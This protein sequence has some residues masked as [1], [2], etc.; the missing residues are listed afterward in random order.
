MRRSLVGS[1]RMLGLGFAGFYACLVLYNITVWLPSHFDE[2]P[3]PYF[4]LENVLV[5]FPDFDRGVWSH[6]DSF[7]PQIWEVLIGP[8]LVMSVGAFVSLKSRHGLRFLGLDFILLSSFS[9]MS[10]LVG[11]LAD[12]IGRWFDPSVIESPSRFL[13]RISLSA[14]VG[15]LIAV[16]NFLPF[17]FVCRDSTDPWAGRLLRYICTTVLPSA[18]VSIVTA[19]TPYVIVR[20]GNTE[21]QTLQWG[22][23]WNPFHPRWDLTFEGWRLIYLP[24]ISVATIATLSAIFAPVLLNRYRA[25]SDSGASH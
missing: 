22:V 23:T 25:I 11:L 13:L 8:I 19:G 5:Y 4:A 1:L 15:L 10:F 16:A 2:K 7:I 12:D 3:W 20:M 21:R 17:Y 6:G 14:I 18:I 9:L 24:V